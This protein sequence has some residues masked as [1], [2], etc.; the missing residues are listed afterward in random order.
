LRIFDKA[1][2]NFIMF[3]LEPA[4]V[5]FS[6]GLYERKQLLKENAAAILSGSL[7]SAFLGTVFLMCC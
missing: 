6:F 7:S 3:F 1:A 2:G 5:S 4:I